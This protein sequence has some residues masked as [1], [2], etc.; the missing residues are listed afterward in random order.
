MEQSAY[1][2]AVI[3]SRAWNVCGRRSDVEMPVFTFIV[4]LAF[5]DSAVCGPGVLGSS[6][7]RLPNAAGGPPTV[8]V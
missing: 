2:C 7:G 3:A 1:Q 8:K 4:Q 6:G 5:R